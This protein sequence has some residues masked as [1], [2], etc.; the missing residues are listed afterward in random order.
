MTPIAGLRLAVLGLGAASGA[1]LVHALDLGLAKENPPFAV[2]HLLFGLLAAGAAMPGPILGM[3]ASP[4][5][6]ESL[7]GLAVGGSAFTALAAVAAGIFVFAFGR[8]GIREA[9][10]LAWS[11]AALV[12]CAIDGFRLKEGAP[13]PSS[14]PPPPPPPL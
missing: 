3:V 1:L 6:G 9:V 11:V 10:V 13:P 12:L 7:R 2:S 5:S 4:R 8:R 14:P